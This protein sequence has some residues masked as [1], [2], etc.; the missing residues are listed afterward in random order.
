MAPRVVGD[1]AAD[2]DMAVDVRRR[3]LAGWGDDAPSVGS[4]TGKERIR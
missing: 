4:G 1:W 3:R 2:V